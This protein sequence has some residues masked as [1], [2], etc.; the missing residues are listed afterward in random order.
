[1]SDESYYRDG[2]INIMI[3]FVSQLAEPFLPAIETA[4][5]RYV[6][7]LSGT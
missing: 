1:M 5:G 2:R 7:V 3:I 6:G 4:D